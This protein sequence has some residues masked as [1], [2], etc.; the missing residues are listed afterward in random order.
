MSRNFSR[1]CPTCLVG[2]PHT[3]TVLTTKSGLF[4][5]SFYQ[6]DRVLRLVLNSERGYEARSNCRNIPKMESGPNL[7]RRMYPPKVA[8]NLAFST[9]QSNLYLTPPPYHQQQ[10]FNLKPTSNHLQL[11]CKLPTP[12]LTPI[13]HL[14]SPHRHTHPHNSAPG[15][16]VQP[17]H[18][19]P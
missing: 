16:H 19:E 2:L 17:Q 8:S 11:P 4:H 13:L 18:P 10:A 9:P 7:Q 3:E 6:I 5:G 14:P 15:K 12:H 1:C